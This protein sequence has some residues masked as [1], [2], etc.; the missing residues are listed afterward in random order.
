MLQNAGD[1]F[2]SSPSSLEPGG[3]CMISSFSQIARPHPMLAL[4]ARFGR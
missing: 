2:I 4:D 1:A 3:I